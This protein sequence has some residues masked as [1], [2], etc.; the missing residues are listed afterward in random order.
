MVDLFLSLLGALRS[1]FRSRADLT[2]ENLALRQQLANLRRTSGRPHLRKADRAFWIALSRLWSRWADVI[3]LV[4]P[5]T[6]VRW[7]RAGFRLFWRWKSRSRSPADFAHGNATIPATICG[8]ATAS[9]T[10][11]SALYP[12]TPARS[13]RMTAWRGT[14]SF[15]TRTSFRV[16]SSLRHNRL[17][18]AQAL[19]AMMNGSVVGS[20]WES[21]R[22]EPQLTQSAP[23]VPASPSSQNWLR[24]VQT[25]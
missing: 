4:K 18:I 25:S 19:T 7:H 8:C 16:Q 14:A 24:N 5:D 2:L 20:L 3:V 13:G 10:Q 12:R 9:T 21:P 11:R 15:R 22:V 23:D 17:L 6:V 1:A